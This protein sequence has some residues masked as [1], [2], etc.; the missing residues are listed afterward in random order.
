MNR[1]LFCEPWPV[2]NFTVSLDQFLDG[3]ISLFINSRRSSSPR[4]CWHQAW[5]P[6][7]WLA[8]GRLVVAFGGGSRDRLFPLR[9]R[10]D[11]RLL[12]IGQNLG[13]AQYRDLVAIAA[14]AAR[15][16][17]AALLERDDL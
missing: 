4:S 16:L 15:I 7:T 9:P 12:A 1:L 10:S 5:P 3:I 14:L 17:A 8:T 6:P 2:S 13:D 11:R